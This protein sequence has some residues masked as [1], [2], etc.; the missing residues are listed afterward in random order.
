MYKIMKRG[1][2]AVDEFTLIMKKKYGSC[3]LAW[4]FLCHNFH[5]LKIMF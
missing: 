2:D 4:L 1:T 3:P 5:E